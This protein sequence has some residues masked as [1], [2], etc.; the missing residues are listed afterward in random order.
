MKNTIQFSRF[1][2][3]AHAKQMQGLRLYGTKTAF[4]QLTL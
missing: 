3:F 2:H 1:Y 4:V